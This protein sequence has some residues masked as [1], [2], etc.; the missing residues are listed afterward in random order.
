LGD[1]LVGIHNGFDLIRKLNIA[2][3]AIPSDRSEIELAAL[4]P[5]VQCGA[6]CYKHCRRKVLGTWVANPICE[7]VCVAERQIDCNSGSK[8]VKI[9]GFGFG[10]NALVYYACVA[11]S[12]AIPAACGA[13][14]V[15]SVTPAAPVGA[16]SCTAAGALAA[17]ICGVSVEVIKGAAIACIASAS[18]IDPSK[19]NFDWKK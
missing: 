16:A 7:T 10:V 19:I 9:C 1:K 18:G 17:G 13:A 14:A 5:E 8:E 6:D 12:G 4:V 3:R 11:A 2:S 15:S